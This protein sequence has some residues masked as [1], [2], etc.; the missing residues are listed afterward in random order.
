MIYVIIF[1]RRLAFLKHLDKLYLISQILK[2]VILA[3]VNLI[4]M[5]GD[6]L[7]MCIADMLKSSDIP[8]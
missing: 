2:T 1:R 6:N 5:R 8:L 3:T 7:K 4:H